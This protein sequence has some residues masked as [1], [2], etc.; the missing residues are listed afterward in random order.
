MR[1]KKRLE[2]EIINP[3]AAGIDI[4]SRSHFV[5]VGQSLDDVKEF[6]VYAGDLESICLHL[7]EYEI[8]AV[9]MESTGDYW[10]NLFTSL[11]KHGFEVTLCNG[12]FTK[13]AKG[14]KTDVKDA[15]WI[16]KL[17]SLGLLTSSF[18]PDE[19]TEILRTYCRQ[20][21]NMINLASGASRKM[22]KY[23]KFLNFRLDVVVK[24]VH[25]G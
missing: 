6:G 3:N 1:R 20:R 13:H 4:G 15:R 17:H 10:Q 18:L 11:I 12:K 25:V 7:K 21:T 8:T 22:Q 9:A 14:K 19:T 16:Q 23:L 2:M 24:D 5:A